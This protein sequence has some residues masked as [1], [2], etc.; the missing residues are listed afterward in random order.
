MGI[1]LRATGRHL[2]YGI[3][4]TQCYLPPPTQVNTPRYNPGEPGRYLIYVPRGMEGWVDL[5]S[6][7]AARPGIEPMTTWSQV[8]RPNRYITKP[9]SS[10]TMQIWLSMLLDRPQLHTVQ[11]INL[12]NRH[13]QKRPHTHDSK[14][15]FS[16]T[17]NWH[18]L[19]DEEHKSRGRAFQTTGAATCKLMAK[20][21]AHPWDK[22]IAEFGW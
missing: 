11:I 6:L 10:H 4:I 13:S 9:P 15:G 22:H 17:M 1:H 12:F 19:T 3:Q 7:T 18:R 20:L 8:Q 5:G 14:M 2:P 16:H 21:T